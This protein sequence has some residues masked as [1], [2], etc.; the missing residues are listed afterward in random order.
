MFTF[1]H[2]FTCLVAGP[3]QSGKTHFIFELLKNL[4]VLIEPVPTKIIWCYGE[5]Q[6]KLDD[7]PANVHKSYALEAL[8]QI[9]PAEKN[10]VII[11]DLMDEAGNSKQVS[12]LFTK[13]SHHRNL[14]VILVVQNLFHQGKVMRTISLNSHYIIL[15]KNPRDMGQI[16]HLATQSFPGKLEFLNKAFKMATKRPHGYLLLDFSPGRSDDRQVWSDILPF[17]DGPAF[18]VPE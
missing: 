6:E 13:G 4:H 17:E 15:F 1:K 11:D 14:S 5:Y 12:K 16:T 9:N 7:L 10:L 3:T 8:D 2:P 18:Y